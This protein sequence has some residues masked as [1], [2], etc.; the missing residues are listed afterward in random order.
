MSYLV[1]ILRDFC[2]H[3]RCGIKTTR[4]GSCT[5]TEAHDCKVLKVKKE[6]WR[7]QLIRMGKTGVLDLS[8]I[9]PVM[10]NVCASCICKRTCNKEARPQKCPIIKDNF[11]FMIDEGKTLGK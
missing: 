8:L 6:E 9:R 2:N 5:S 4:A 11:R 3:K 10:D 7:K 1:K